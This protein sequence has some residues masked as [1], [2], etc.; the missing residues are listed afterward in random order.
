MCKIIGLKVYNKLAWPS[1]SEISAQKA[2]TF[3]KLILNL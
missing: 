1:F 2:L 3:E